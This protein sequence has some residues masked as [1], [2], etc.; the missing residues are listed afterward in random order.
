RRAR[1]RRRAGDPRSLSPALPDP[2][3]APA[4]DRE[5]PS[6][7]SVWTAIDD[8]A[9]RDLPQPDLGE[10]RQLSFQPVPHPAGD[11]FGGGI[12]DEI[13]EVRMID[14]VEDLLLDGF[15]HVAEID[16]DPRIRIGL[17]AQHHLKTIVVAV[18]VE[19]LALVSR[20]PVGGRE[21]EF[22]LDLM[23]ALDS[24]GH[25]GCRPRQSAAPGRFERVWNL[26]GPK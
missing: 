19:A 22:R 2:A 26:L 13:I 6:E 12:L 7:P 18:Q 20:K 4:A 24:P 11:V 21:G 15:F 1:P 10:P 5:A 3:C 8:A 16:E 25:V 9:G 14:L 17:A 23:H